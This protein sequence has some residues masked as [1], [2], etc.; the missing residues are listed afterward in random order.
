MQMSRR[1]NSTRMAGSLT[2]IT[3]MEESERTHRVPDILPAMTRIAVPLLVENVATAHAMAA[4]A[5]E[6]GADLVEYRIDRFTQDQPTITELVEQSPLPCIVTCRIAEEGGAFQ[7]E[8]SERVA[9]YQAA[10]AGGRKPAYLDVELAAWERSTILREGITP[11][12]QRDGDTG[13]ILSC[14]DF[15]TRPATLYQSI[16][17]MAQLDACRVIKVAWMAR[18]LRDNLEAFEVISQ[19][20]KPTIALCMG[21]VGLP[22]RVLA[23]KAD[24]LLTF[25]AAEADAGTAPGQPTV[26]ELKRLYRWDH[27]QA[28]TKVYGVIGYPVAHSMSPAIHN[29]GFD[30]VDFDG[31]Y[32]HMPIPPEYEHFKAT[33]DAWLIAPHLHFRGASVT[34]PHKENLIRFVLE[35]G[36]EIEP[37]AAT[38]GAANTLTVRDD[39]ALLASNSDYAAALDAVCGGMGITRD[40]LAGQRVAVIGAGG[41]ARAIVAGFAAGGAT[42]VI[43]NRTLER[44]QALAS[45]FS[46]TPGKVVAAAIEKLCDSCCQ[47]YINCT[48]IGMHPNI[49]ASPIP[50][51]GS[52]KRIFQPGVVVFDTIYNP[53]RTKLLEAARAAGCVTISG[54]EMF[55]R[56]A[57]VQFELWTG[58]EAPI[59]AFEQVML[60]KLR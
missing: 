35:R 59:K 52:A 23:K 33:V 6:V 46:G 4:R 9:A 20:Y 36:G 19:Q 24:A 54:T 13:L 51:D 2:D 7:G 31:V 58:K 5:A 14:H 29:A 53:T 34:I 48:P 57:A 27:Q 30:A 8:A 56:Q 21:E 38:I 12:V 49:N 16:E 18:S 44:A 37:L 25:A 50:L 32:L 3:A 45:E 55:T 17:K 42:V 15:D 26:E 60:E 22:S 10:C 41:A 40:D 11:L 1:I 28:G 43:Y 47:I 39:G